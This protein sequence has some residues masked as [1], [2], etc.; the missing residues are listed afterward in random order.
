MTKAQNPIKFQ[1]PM[2]NDGSMLRSPS[3]RIGLGVRS[4]DNRRD[5]DPT[6]RS[7]VD[8]TPARLFPVPSAGGPK[9]Q[10]LGGTGAEPPTSFLVAV[11]R[12]S[13]L[14]RWVAVQRSEAALGF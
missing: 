3:R 4:K 7:G 6:A 11:F 2:S 8:E 14:F 13:L 10:N 1:S 5:G 12:A 9:A